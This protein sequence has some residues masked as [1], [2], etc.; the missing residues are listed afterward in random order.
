MTQASSYL[1]LATLFL[2]LIGAILVMFVPQGERDLARGIGLG[3]AIL[4]FLVSLAILGPFDGAISTYQLVFDKEWIPGLGAHFKLG[5]DGISIWLVLLTTFLTPV[6]LLSAH[7]SISEKVREFVAAM[8]VLE[9]AMVGTF[10]AL[11]VFL[12]YVFWELML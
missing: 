1:L 6:V 2:P 12:F 5:V 10:L 4:T 11:D 3:V 7:A 8:L 9:V